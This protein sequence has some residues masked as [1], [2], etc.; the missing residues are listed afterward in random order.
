VL[1]ARALAQQP[2]LLVLDEP[3]AFLD[4]PSRVRMVELLRRLAR[5]SDVAVLLSTHDLELALRVADAVWLLDRD[6]RLWTGT[7]EELALSGAVGATFDAET[8]RFDPG[9][10][11]FQASPLEGPGPPRTARVVAAGARGPALVR[12]LAREGWVVTGDG[13][14]D[15]IITAA[16]DGSAVVRHDGAATAVS[17]LGALARTVR[18]L[19]I[20]TVR[21]CDPDA[22]TATLHDLARLG[23]YFA[24]STGPVEDAG[25]LPVST[26]QGDSAALAAVVEQ[27]QAR[28]GVTER[29][30]AVSTLFQGYAARL[31]SVGLGALVRHG[32]VPDLDPRSLLWQTHAGT[33]RLHLADPQGWQGSGALDLLHRNVIEDHLRPLAAAAHRLG[34]LAD[35]LLWGDAASALLGAARVLDAAPVGPAHT[36]AD[37]LLDR[38]PLLGAVSSRPDGSRQRRSCCLYYRVPGAGLCGDCVLS[39]PPTH[40]HRQPSRSTG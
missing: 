30:V 38:P 37:L 1:T 10:G 4:V 22:V 21:G 34:P 28:L 3:T 17:D 39:T 19:P 35:G 31:W 2:D 11:V 27:L 23:Q 18:A 8:L 36:V 13:P 7:P 25:W 29:R 40:L 33:V 9:T 32:Q 14:A 12:L 24:V 16:P 20:S 5:T 6:S 26:V 15:A